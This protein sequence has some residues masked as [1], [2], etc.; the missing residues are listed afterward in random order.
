MKIIISTG[1][2]PPEIGGPSEYARKLFETLLIQNHDVT[3]VTYGSLK[4]F[5]T[6]FRHFL[7]FCRLFLGAYDTD[8]IIA[9]DTYSVGLPAVIFAILL[10]KKIVIR[11]AG[12]F[13][14]ESYVERTRGPIL[15]SDF[16]NVKRRY[17]FKEKIIFILTKFLLKYAN[18]VV[19][20]TEWQRKIMLQAYE[21]SLKKTT[22]IENFY[23]SV[24]FDDTVTS[25]EKVF[26]SPSRDRFIKN[27][28]NLEEA[29]ARIASHYKDIVLDTK[30]VAHEVLMEKIPKAYAVIVPS[31][32][33]V[34][35]N[36]AVDALQHS[37]PIIVTKD[38][39]IADRLK[40]MAMFIDPLSVESIQNGIESLL[41]TETYDSY[42]HKI[43]QSKFTH[44]W[45]EIAQEFLDLYKTL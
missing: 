17:S 7:Y 37:V 33:E 19:F 10:K 26:L 23:P 22:I 40:D 9:M 39:G 4:K 11:V 32:S 6:G 41:N 14:W 36:L 31:L 25:P 45:N 1:I 35:P 27:K 30:V 16:Y 5:T 3:I 18:S 15:L 44:S 24:K 12:D 21:I 34:S 13:L 28:K 20:S 43:M 38:T 8:Y 42:R 29:F 2:Y